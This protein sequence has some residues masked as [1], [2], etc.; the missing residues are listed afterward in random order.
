[1][2]RAK[3]FASAFLIA[4]AVL[5][6]GAKRAGDPNTLSKPT[7][8]GD[9]VLMDV[10]NI[11]TP[12]RNNGS[13]DRDPGTGNAGFEWPKGTGNTAIYASGLWMGGRK[14]GQVSV[15]VA[16]YSYEFDAGPMT[17]GG[18]W[19]DPND[20][21]HRVYRIN[22][23]DGP[24]NPDYANWP[25]EYGAPV[26][27]N[28]N[29]QIIGDAT[30]WCVFNDADPSTHTNMNAPPL[31]VEVQLTAFGFNRSD[32]L[33]N[34][35]FFKWK[36]INKSGTDIEDTYISVWSDID[37]GDSGDD[38][39]GCDT[40][41]GLGFTY[42]GDPEDGVYGFTPPVPGFDFLQGPLVDGAPTDTARFPDGRIFPGK[43]L[44]KMTAY[45]KYSN[46]ATDLG[47]PS[48]GT[49]V[50]NYM[51]GLTRNGL[52][53]LDPGGNPSTFMFSGDPSQPNSATN[54]IETDNP[55][56]RRL[57][58]SSGPFTMA[59]GDTQE[60]VAASLIAQGSDN[61]NS[62]VALKNADA[63]VQTAYDLNFNL[64]PPPDAPIV[65]A[66][67]LDQAV[68]F[69]WGDDAASAD[70]VE[71]TSTLDP[72][73]EAAGASKF[74]YDFE[75]YVVYQVANASGD[76]PQIVATFDLPGNIEPIYDDVFDPSVG[77]LVN[78]PVR[79]GNNGGVQRTIRIT[80][81]KYTGLRLSNAK[82]YY[83]VV[84]A[85]SYNEES[86]PKTLESALNVMTVRPTKLP[87]RRL[88]S[89]FGD[90]LA[91]THTGTSDGSAVALVV[92]PAATTGHDYNVEFVVDT[93]NGGFMWQVRDVT[94]NLLVVTE[95][96]NETGDGA[97]P[98][99]DGVQVK[100]QGPPLLGK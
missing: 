39:D 10:N 8:S 52:Q 58:M 83:F 42:N 80:S 79:F 13:F 81:D 59:A 76:N 65:N 63:S 90:T 4:L 34:A 26:D 14:G 46:D 47:N 7:L 71:A 36:V 9:H 73:A 15:A 43:K 97:Y 6:L 82:D 31:G 21:L 48:T 19:A 32:A 91:V 77:N 27:E 100:P 78:K 24:E 2:K 57:L 92:D 62:V 56:D 89:A 84:S 88:T 95:Q 51:Q 44:L 61:L 3:Y 28:G 54:W 45:L 11:S 55:G 75:G 99:F 60:I 29:P 96:K 69:S 53:I 68:I 70:A 72:I 12:I 33:G 40:T 94:S 86:V 93:A 35:L 22:R 67:T 23:G 20:P 17:A 74:T 1:M 87:G 18:G 37:L 16:E 30:V 98:T 25:V 85:Y 49:E 41:L 38:L 5:S 66:T 64:A 50:H